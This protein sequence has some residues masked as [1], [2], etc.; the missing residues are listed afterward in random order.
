M[1]D[2]ADDK[3][4]KIGKVVHYYDKIGVAVVKLTA[5]LGLGDEVKMV[6]GDNEFKQKIDSMQMDHK[7]VNKAKK[8]EEIAIKVEKETKRGA[9][10][11]LVS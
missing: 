8:G 10:V 1:A 11:Y 9:E 3:D 4:K 5:A 6:K 2:K 7:A